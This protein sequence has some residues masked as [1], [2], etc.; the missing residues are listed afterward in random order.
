MYTIHTHTQK[1]TLLRDNLICGDENVYGK[2]CC[3]IKSLQTNAVAE[4]NFVVVRKLSH[5]KELTLNFA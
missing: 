2:I 5:H 4:V 3:A 1:K